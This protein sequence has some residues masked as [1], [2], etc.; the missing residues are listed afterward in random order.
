MLIEILSTF[1]GILCVVIIAII[2]FAK[3]DTS[4]L[5][6]L[7][8][9]F[10]SGN[11]GSRTIRFRPIT[12]VIFVLVIMFFSNSILLNKLIADKAKNSSIIHEEPVATVNPETPVIQENT[13]AEEP[14]NPNSES[15]EIIE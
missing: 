15:M 2:Y 7:S 12:K 8:Q 1:H 13:N 5:S 6:A 14:N 3:P 10:N 9:S 11:G 4:G